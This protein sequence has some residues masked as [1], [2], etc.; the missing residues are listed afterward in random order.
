MGIGVAGNNCRVCVVIPCYK[1]AATLER[2]LRSVCTQSRPVDEIVVVNDC[3][4]E[5]LAIEEILTRFPEARYVKNQRNVGLAATRNIGV[6]AS[7]A[8]IVSFLDADDE[9]HPQKIE[10]QLSLYRPDIAVTCRV[11]HIGNEIGIAK[12]EQFSGACPYSTVTDSRSIIRWNRLTGASILISRALF[13]KVGGY[14]DSL[15]SCEDFDLWLR[16]LD[17]GVQVYDVQLPLYLYRVNEVGLSRNYRNISRWELEVVKKYFE[18]YRQVGT[19]MPGEGTTLAFWLMKHLLRYETCLDRDL[20][21]AT[22]R[23]I[24]LLTP[25]PLVK[26]AVSL[27]LHLRVLRIV[28][29]MR[30]SVP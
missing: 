1:D 22:A 6:D 21:G 4:P 20:L 9:L 17:A 29:M 11:K 8:E 14:D 26:A 10:Y 27:I 18:R 13:L 16:L 24:E 3:S 28:V 25:W 7:S 15:R 5:T 19:H 2:A 30:R 12:I 23:N